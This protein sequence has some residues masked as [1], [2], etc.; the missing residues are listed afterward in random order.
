MLY[1]VTVSGYVIFSAM[2]HG[3]PSSSSIKFG[4]GVMTV[5]AEKSTR[6]PIK[7]PRIRPALP[8]KRS[9]IDLM[10]RPLRVKARG[11][12]ATVLSINVMMWYWRSSVNSK[13][14]C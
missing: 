8:F 12:P 7:F 6:L 14:T 13:M 11:I 1:G 3:T 2:D 5:R 10:G 4:S 9:E